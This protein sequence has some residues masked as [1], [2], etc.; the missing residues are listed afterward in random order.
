MTHEPGESPSSESLQ[1]HP[2]ETE[3]FAF[4][5]AGSRADP[6]CVYARMDALCGPRAPAWRHL[7]RAPPLRASLP[8]ASPPRRKTRITRHVPR[9]LG[10]LPQHPRLG[11][12][13]PHP[14]GPLRSQQRP[15]RP[16]SRCPGSR[17]PG[18][19]CLG[20]PSNHGRTDREEARAKHGGPA[21]A[22]LN[23]TTC[24]SVP[25]F[26]ANDSYSLL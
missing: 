18:S 19:R 9:P 23:V 14:G 1:H 10:A 22:H 16:G 21:V 2:G 3:C 25:P 20:R 11:P 5:H 7:V 26:N 12:D 13:G 17:R 24:A 6:A 4:A 8:A 15:S